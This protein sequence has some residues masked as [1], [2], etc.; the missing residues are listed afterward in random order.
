MVLWFTLTVTNSL[1]VS[2]A[3]DVTTVTVQPIPDTI[4]ITLVEY[5][6]GKQR[7]TV[8]ATSSVVSPNLDLTL[9][10]Y[11]ST[12]GATVAG[13]AMTNLGTGNYQIVL[14]GVPQPN[15]TGVTVTSNMGGT[16]TSPIT[17]LR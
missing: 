8:N 1:R 16:R 15:A 10:P 14:V 5:R 6:T 13:G 11:T 3:P 17:R 2:S 12:S 4:T 7:L 9:Q